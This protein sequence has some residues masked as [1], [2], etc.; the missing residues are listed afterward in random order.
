MKHIIIILFLFC[1]SS[2]YSYNHPIQ[3]NLNAKY[4][5]SWADYH[6]DQIF[7][8]L[9]DI[10]VNNKRVSVFSDSLLKN[11]ITTDVIV[12]EIVQFEYNKDTTINIRSENYFSKVKYSFRFDSIYYVGLYKYSTN[13]INVYPVCYVRWSDVLFYLSKEELFLSNLL[14]KKKKL[15]THNNIFIEKADA[16]NIY[17][18]LH[19]TIED[20]LYKYT[21]NALLPIYDN[22]CLCSEIS[23]EALDSVLDRKVLVFVDDDPSS[24]PWNSTKD[25]VITQYYTHGYSVEKSNMRLLFHIKE[26]GGIEWVAIASLHILTFANTASLQPLAYV[27][28]D[29]LK[30]FLSDEETQA[31]NYL[32]W[33][34][35]Y[36]NTDPRGFSD[37]FKYRA[38][39]EKVE[40]E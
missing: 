11:E 34:T 3:I 33:H 40:D 1:I 13:Q 28:K 17:N 31:I 29:D 32:A 5:E 35:M 27:K 25:T 14:I 36:V 2:G 4:Y 24:C 39:P 16:K 7:K 20:K 9:S 6:L 21:R 12:R 19:F 22:E 26:S 8:K 30:L 10:V 23:K 18:M 37:L 15:H 38:E